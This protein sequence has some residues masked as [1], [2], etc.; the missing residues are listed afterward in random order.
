GKMIGFDVLCIDKDAEQFLTLNMHYQE[1]MQQRDINMYKRISEIINKGHRAIVVTGLFHA[2]TNE[3]GRAAYYLD[4]E[5]K[6]EEILTINF[7]A[8]L[9]D[10]LKNLY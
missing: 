7:T 1:F 5:L 2:L 4:K 3:E 10:N 6:K 8:V 9:R